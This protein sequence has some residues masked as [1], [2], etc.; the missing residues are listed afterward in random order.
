MTKIP[1]HYALVFWA[2]FALAAANGRMALG[3]GPDSGVGNLSGT[4]V[5]S[6]IAV[7]PGPASTIT[8]AEV[9]FDKFDATT[10]TLFVADCKRSSASK[11]ALC[12]PTSTPI[13]VNDKDLKTQI[14]SFGI[15]DHLELVTDGK[16][17]PSLRG[18]L[19]KTNPAPDKPISVSGR[20]WLFVACM[21]ALLLPT[22]VILALASRK[23][24]ASW[25]PLV[26]NWNP[27]SLVLGE[28]NRYSNSKCQMA[29]WFYILIASYLYVTLFRYSYAG[30]DFI[31]GISIPQTLLMLSGMSALTFAGAKGITTAK[32]N[33]AIQA[34]AA[35]LATPVATKTT[36]TRTPSL[37]SDLLSNDTGQ[38]DFG[39]FQMLVV[40]VLAVGMYLTLLFHF[41]EV[42]EYRHAITLPDVDTTIL[43]TFG[44]GQ[45]A[46][47]AKK[48]AGNV[49]SS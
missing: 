17:S 18:I 5:G 28:D 42:V 1:A 19:L 12:G 21:A 14:S 27:L 47:L 3:Q 34:N 35:G 37:F 32:Q 41:T 9:R 16:P 40:T 10:N 13:L 38:F 11:T 22:S 7:L 33:A 23:S 15:G 4:P 48:A 43:A 20:I 25:N 24:K 6:R 2:V 49:G 44:L 30:A 36:N 29:L 8:Y 26:L 31:G 46:Y 45:G 39:D